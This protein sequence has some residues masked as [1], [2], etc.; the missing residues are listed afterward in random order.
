MTA[1]LRRPMRIHRSIT[2]LAAT[3]IGA[4]TTIMLLCAAALLIR[5]GGDDDGTWGATR[6]ADVLKNAVTRNEQGQLSIRRTHQLDALMHDFP[7]F[8][9]IVSDKAGEVSYGPVPKW[10]PPKAALQQNGTSFLA[11]AIDRETGSLNLK[12][13]AAVRHTPLGEI[14]ILT[15]GVSYTAAQLTFGMLTDATVIAFPIILVL[16]VTAITAMVFVPTLIARP[17]RAVT[18]A[19]ELIDGVP[20]GRR[21]PED[22]APT[23]LLP[24][25]AAFNRALCRIDMASGAQRTFL[26]YA[27]HELR[28]PLTNARTTLEKIQDPALRARLIAE[29]E[30]LSSIVTML[31]QLARISMEPTEQTKVDLVALARR[32]AAE[33]APMAV[34]NGSDIEFAEPDS[35]V[36]VR[37]SET[38]ISVAISNL[39]RNA[40]Y[41]GRSERPILIEVDAPARLS[42]VDSGI[43]L[44]RGRRED[45]PEPPRRGNGRTEGTGLGLSIVSQVMATHNGSVAIGDTPGG[46]TTVEL[47]FPVDRQAS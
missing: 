29:N 22:K 12:K 32:V 26:S 16:V 5:F 15:G 18:H 1:E 11:F 37:G 43:G 45:P 14:S 41:H 47:R 21:L 10:V 42:V 2:L 35:P 33:H 34:K 23:E 25:V 28:T 19:A 36:W 13:T 7:T 40:A 38:A 31:L 17:I 46:G 4:V 39:I 6:V 8:W 20:D 24:L 9:Y 27:A 44:R 30:R 3:L